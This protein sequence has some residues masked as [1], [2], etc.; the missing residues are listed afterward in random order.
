MADLNLPKEVI[1]R[2]TALFRSNGYIRGQNPNKRD[3]GRRK[4]HKGYEVRF[5]A[6]S[7]AELKRIRRLLRSAG[8][9]VGRPFKKGNQWRQPLYGADRVERLLTLVGALPSTSV[10]AL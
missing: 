3:L 8:F 9:A 1:E 7:A 6:H 10:P 4:Y 5:I 2:L